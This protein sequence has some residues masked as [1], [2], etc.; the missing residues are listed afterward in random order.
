MSRL[1]ISTNVYLLREARSYVK[2]LKPLDEFALEKSTSPVVLTQDHI[3]EWLEVFYE[4]RIIMNT[5]NE[6]RVLR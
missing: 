2:E 3:V 1:D 5:C 4:D 6:A